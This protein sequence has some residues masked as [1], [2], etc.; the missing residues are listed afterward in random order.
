MA[1]RYF[2]RL[3]ELMAQLNESQALYI[4]KKFHREFHKHLHRQKKLLGYLQDES[5]NCNLAKSF[6]PFYILQ[7]KYIQNFLLVF[8]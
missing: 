3:C 2:S 1:L 5:H 7:V 4:L 8:Y 6:E